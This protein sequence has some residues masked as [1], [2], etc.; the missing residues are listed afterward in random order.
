VVYDNL[1]TMLPAS[2]KELTITLSSLPKREKI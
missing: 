1:L 2:D